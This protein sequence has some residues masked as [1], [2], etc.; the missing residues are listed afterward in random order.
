MPP[1]RASKAQTAGRARV[2]R[3]EEVLGV[4]PRDTHF[5]EKLRY[6]RGEA[7]EAVASDF[8]AV[9]LSSVAR[10][11]ASDTSEVDDD[12]DKDRQ[13]TGAIFEQLLAKLRADGRL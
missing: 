7:A 1:L 5:E 8:Y 6:D 12:V 10:H 4:K 13:S 2:A 3:F 9:V 11:Y